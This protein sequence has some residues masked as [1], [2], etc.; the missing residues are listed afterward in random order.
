MSVNAGSN[1]GPA[2]PEDSDGIQAQDQVTVSRA[3]ARAQE[4]EKRLRE[5]VARMD[6]AQ[7]IAHFGDWEW[8]IEDDR[9]TWSDEL[10][11]I[12]GFEPGSAPSDA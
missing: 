1:P 2:P 11:R 3:L 9:I 5:V 6:E 8:L 7:E 10:C 12:F 4:S